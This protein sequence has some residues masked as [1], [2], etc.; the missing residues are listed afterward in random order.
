MKINVRSNVDSIAK[1]ME[2]KYKKQMPY[3]TSKAI[4]VVT[5]SAQKEV[6][7]QIKTLDNPTPFTV[8]GSFVKLSNKNQSPIYAI[9]GVKDKQA[10]YLEYTEEGGTSRATGK[11]KPVPVP[12]SKNKYGNLPRGTTK[13]IGKGK[14]FSGTPKGRTIAGIYQRAGTK[15]NPKLRMLASWHSSTQHHKR[16]R[17]GERVRLRVRRDFERELMRQVAAAIKTAR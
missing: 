8:K 3:A 9:V 16:T 10:K 15:K 2:R 14:V 6:D 1:G 4:N 11:A 7:R 17:I 13:K 5:K 12:S